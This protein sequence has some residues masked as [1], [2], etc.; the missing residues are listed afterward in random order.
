MNYAIGKRIESFRIIKNLSRE[1]MAKN[2]NISR[3]QYEL[4]ESGNVDFSFEIL[5]RISQC[6]SIEARELTNIKEFKLTSY[7]R[8]AGLGDGVIESI[9]NIEKLMQMYNAQEKI[10]NQGKEREATI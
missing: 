7:F 9:S 2:L 3:E 10:Y 1:E 6:L 5:N 8:D 4:I